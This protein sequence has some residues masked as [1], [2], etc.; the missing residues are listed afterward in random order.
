MSIRSTHSTD[1]ETRKRVL[2]GVLWVIIGI[3]LFTTVIYL[4]NRSVIVV[5]AETMGT[6][7]ITG[8]EMLAEITKLQNRCNKLE[9]EVNLLKANT[10]LVN[11]LV[12]EDRMTHDILT[13]IIF[14]VKGLTTDV[15]ML[16]ENP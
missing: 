11:S 15:E 3:V 9:G 14:I 8:A 10:F 5:D 2:T 1:T 7:E 16:K 13:N 4:L 12:K 6:H